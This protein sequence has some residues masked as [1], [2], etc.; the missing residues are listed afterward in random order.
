ME[1]VELR[2]IGQEIV[3][4]VNTFGV[5][6]IDRSVNGLSDDSE[7]HVGL[8][9]S[10]LPSSLIASGAKTVVRASDFVEFGGVRKAYAK[11]QVSGVAETTN[12][13]LN[14]FVVRKVNDNGKETETLIDNVHAT[15]NA[16]YVYL[17]P[18]NN[19]TDI[20]P[21]RFQ[22]TKARLA[23]KVT[24]EAGGV[25]ISGL[26]T[27]NDAE[28]RPYHVRI[29]NAAGMGMYSQPTTSES[30]FVPLSQHGVYVLSTGKDVLKF[31]F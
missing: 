17:Q 30:I 12:A 14:L 20:N 7:L 19:P 22:D 11:V 13:L 25:R 21:V 16:H 15:D 2:L 1:D 31:Q 28:G 29:F 6:L 18:S 5:E 4:G 8:F 27:G 24:A 23:V 3:N 9:A 26:P 10:P